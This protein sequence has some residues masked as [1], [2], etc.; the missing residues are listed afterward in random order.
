VLALAAAFGLGHAAWQGAQLR[1]AA[2]PERLP[3]AAELL[4][5]PL[6]LADFLESDLLAGQTTLLVGESRAWFY[7]D[8][9][10]VATPFDRA[11]LA[12]AWR[13]GG[14]DPRRVLEVLRERGVTQIVANLE[15]LQRLRET[16]GADP[17]VTPAAL[18]ALVRAGARE[19]PTEL[20]GIRVIRVER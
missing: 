7:P 18:D 15:E 9:T 10:R 19:I 5:D 11:P 4:R 17:E 16:Y 2:S 12:D 20:P 6:I 1:A 3:P 8:G 13:A 14:G